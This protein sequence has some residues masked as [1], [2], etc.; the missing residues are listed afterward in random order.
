VFVS[1]LFV[2]QTDSVRLQNQTL[3]V[4]LKRSKHE[5]QHG[6]VAEVDHTILG[7]HGGVGLKRETCMHVYNNNN[8]S[9][10]YIF[11]SL[12]VD[13]FT[14]GPGQQYQSASLIIIIIV[15]LVGSP[16][17]RIVCVL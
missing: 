17:M 2:R 15:S 6:S 13:A 14:P 11:A 16:V 5:Q 12:A 1:V 8:T 3:I 7:V 4:M 10:W 9:Y